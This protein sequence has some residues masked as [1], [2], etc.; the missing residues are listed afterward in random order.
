MVGVRREPIA[1]GL[2]LVPGDPEG[3]VNR[4]EGGWVVVVSVVGVIGVS[5]VV[6]IG[7]TCFGDDI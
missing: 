3:S 4:K 2:R 7:V 5:L 1:N 6:T